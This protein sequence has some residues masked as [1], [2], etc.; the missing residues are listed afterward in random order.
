MSRD[1]PGWHATHIRHC[2]AIYSLTSMS[3]KKYRAK[4][5]RIASLRLRLRYFPQMALRQN[6]WV[7]HL[8]ILLD[9][10]IY[11][12]SLKRRVPSVCA[13]SCDSGAYSP[14]AHDKTASKT[15][16]AG[17]SFPIIEFPVCLLLGA[18]FP[19]VLCLLW[20]H[21][22]PSIRIRKAVKPIRKFQADGLSQFQVGRLL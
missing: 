21:S 4:K 16:A 7:R 12:L 15:T 6:V 1:D 22:K 8:F 18:C 3:H 10:G 13:Q 11:H 9:S 14:D 17:R 2:L 19:Y 5:Y 20:R